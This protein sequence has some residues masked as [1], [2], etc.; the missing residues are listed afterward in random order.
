VVGDELTGVAGARWQPSTT[1][2]TIQANSMAPPEAGPTRNHRG[3]K[4]SPKWRSATVSNPPMRSLT[5]PSTQARAVVPAK[6]PQAN[7]YAPRRGLKGFR[8]WA[9]PKRSEA[10]RSPAPKGVPLQ[11]HLLPNRRLSSPWKNPR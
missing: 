5:I 3:K 11:R 7:P 8:R 4:M 2:A 6:L 10:R 1:A 9:I